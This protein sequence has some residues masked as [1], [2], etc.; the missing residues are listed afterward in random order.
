[1]VKIKTKELSNSKFQKNRCKVKTKEFWDLPEP[2]HTGE[3]I[4]PVNEGTP[5]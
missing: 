3:Y 1:M 4:C 2:T 5:P